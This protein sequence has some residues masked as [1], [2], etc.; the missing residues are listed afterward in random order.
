M[1]FQLINS[2]TKI[3]NSFNKDDGTTLGKTIYVDDI[4]GRW[5]YAT[6]HDY[7]STLNN[8]RE[9]NS[10]GEFVLKTNVQ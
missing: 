10:R 6:P 2:P 8:V 4:G 5:E 3:I 1:T 7:N 9:V